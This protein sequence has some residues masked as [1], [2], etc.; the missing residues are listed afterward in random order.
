MADLNRTA[1]DNNTVA[2]QL[3]LTRVLNRRDKCL[4]DGGLR[5][6]YC[7][8]LASAAGVSS[9]TNAGFVASPMLTVAATTAMSCGTVEC[10]EGKAEVMAVRCASS[11]AVAL[12]ITVS[13]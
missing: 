3:Q 11:S 5:S 8:M 10:D 9:P 7:Y 1:T 4:A 13:L 12:N 6:K 2:I